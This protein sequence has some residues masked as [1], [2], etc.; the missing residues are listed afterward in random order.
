MADYLV[1]DTE[2]TSV[3]GAI[4]T[5]GGTQASLS[6]P[7][8]FV[9]AINAIPTGGGGSLPTC[10]MTVTGDPDVVLSNFS[11]GVPSGTY[12]AIATWAVYSGYK[13][14]L[15]FVGYSGATSLSDAATDGG[16]FFATDSAAP[17]SYGIVSGRYASAW[18]TD[19]DSAGDYIDAV[20]NFA[21]TYTAY[22]I[23]L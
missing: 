7:S 23:E 10:T 1:T 22:V 15:I 4:R 20:S 8:G 21:G 2:M 12:V 9:S 6:W 3:A 14:L 16:A 18:S 11:D 5:K 13:S 19:D 17:S